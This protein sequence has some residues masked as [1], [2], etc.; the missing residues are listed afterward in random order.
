MHDPVGLYDRDQALM[1]GR[2]LEKLNFHWYEEPIQDTDMDGLTQLCS[3]LDI[4]VVSLEDLPGSLYTRAQ[5]IARGA[6]DRVR[7][8][9]CNS[10]GITPVK[11]IASLA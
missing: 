10:G 3:A 8:D 2:E 4:P 5:Y 1:V 9:T 6:V 11:K 7:C